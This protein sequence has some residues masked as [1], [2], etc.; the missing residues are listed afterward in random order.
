MNLSL[1]NFKTALVI[2]ALPHK[3]QSHFVELNNVF[4][5]FLKFH[6]ILRIVIKGGYNR[7]FSEGFR[8][9]KIQVIIFEE[10]DLRFLFQRLF[11]FLLAAVNYFLVVGKTFKTK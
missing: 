5:I 3:F 2:L 11:F 6:G 4:V 8:K 10:V 7:S 1:W 9:T